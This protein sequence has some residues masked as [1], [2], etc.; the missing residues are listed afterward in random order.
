MMDSAN[1]ENENDELIWNEREGEAYR[2]YCWR[3]SLIVL[4]RY[5]RYVLV[6]VRREAAGLDGARAGLPQRMK[7][8]KINRV[9]SK[10]K[11]LK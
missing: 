2:L 11:L 5:A 9:N 1:S 3:S 8:A 4:A 10:I 6:V 7:W